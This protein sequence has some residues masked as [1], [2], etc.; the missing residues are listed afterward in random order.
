M[1]MADE[2]VL[3]LVRRVRSTL[4][5]KGPAGAFLLSEL[6]AAISRGVDD[7]FDQSRGRIEPYEAQGRRSLNEGELLEILYGVFDTY[8]ITLPSVASSMTTSLR[9]RFGIDHCEVTLDRSLLADD[10]QSFGRARID[11]II[12]LTAEERVTESIR[13][14][15]RLLKRREK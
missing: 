10:L 15:G 12:P 11:A 6:D 4:Q 1:A 13:E 9:E 14:I 7:L 8:L 3:E 5:A 2:T